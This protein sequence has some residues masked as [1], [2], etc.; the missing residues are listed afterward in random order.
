MFI[1]GNKFFVLYIF[2]SY[3]KQHGSKMTIDQHDGSV[4]C[5]TELCQTKEAHGC[6][7]QASS[8]SS[9]HC[10]WNFPGFEL[11]KIKA[12]TLL[13]C[14]YKKVFLG[15]NFLLFN[16]LSW[17]FRSVNPFWEHSGKVRKIFDMVEERTNIFSLRFH[18]TAQKL[19]VASPALFSVRYFSN[20]ALFLVHIKK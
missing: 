1:I 15:S 19:R 10:I 6:E 17:Y 13:L 4:M 2:V 18:R 20:S 16:N 11:A 8:A 12:K 5:E 14:I 7:P 3:K 9:R